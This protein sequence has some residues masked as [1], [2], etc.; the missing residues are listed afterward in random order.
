MQCDRCQKECGR[1]HYVSADT[2]VCRSCYTP[3]APMDTCRLHEYGQENPSDPQGSTAHVR[4]I[5]S[6]RWDPVEKRTFNW[7]G[8]RAYFF[9]KG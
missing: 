2:W 6:R 4:E 7:T 3:P 8:E 9:P 5:K 1:L